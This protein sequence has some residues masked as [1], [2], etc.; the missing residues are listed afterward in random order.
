MTT[1]TRSLDGTVRTQRIAFTWPSM[2]VLALLFASLRL[3]M[4]V[5]Y[6]PGGYVR[7]FPA[8]GTLGGSAFDWQSWL[9]YGVSPL[10]WLVRAIVS[11]LFSSEV[12]R[13]LAFTTF[14]FPFEIL[15]LSLIYLLVRSH[16]SEVHA[17]RS[18]WVWAAFWFP[19]WMWLTSLEAVGIALALATLWL[20]PR[21]REIAVLVG[22]LAIIWMPFALLVFALVWVL[23]H[24]SHTR[25][26]AIITIVLAPL[27]F[28]PPQEEHLLM[29]LASI[30]IGGAS[31]WPT[32]LAALTTLLFVLHTP[33]VPF[34]FSVE[35]RAIPILAVG[36]GIGMGSVQITMLGRLTHRHHLRAWGGR[37]G[38]A[39]MLGTLLLAAVFGVA[40]WRTLARA[41]SPYASLLDTLAVA[42]AGYVLVGSHELYESIYPFTPS[43][44]T[45]R[46]VSERNADILIE[47]IRNHPAPIWMLGHP[48]EHTAWRQV[49]EQLAADAYT[50]P[51]AWYDTLRLEMLTLVPPDTTRTPSTNFADAVTLHQVAWRTTASPGDIVAVELVWDVP[52]HPIESTVFVHVREPVEDRNLAQYDGTPAWTPGRVI[53]RAAIAIPPDIPAG[54]Y[55]LITGRYIPSTGERVLLADGT[56]EYQIG[57]ITIQS[58]DK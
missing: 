41:Q 24:A 18:A 15:T 36:V 48:L 45:V 10:E 34:L 29:L 38:I 17:R 22:G 32:I 54:T 11:S 16:I 14:T 42:P 35:N 47:T 53:Q 9:L 37:L 3:L 39:G 58:A 8:I 55:A 28:V 46:V 7:P 49:F 2:S 50:T 5:M 31:A 26:W 21:R 52:E 20:V 56:H 23:R 40:D 13:Q 25:R 19:A 33:I 4:A 1:T 6:R 12:A 43:R 44:H 57:T 27:I 51:G 30:A